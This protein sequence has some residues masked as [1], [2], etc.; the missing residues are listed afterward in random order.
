MSAVA[1]PEVFDR[2]V[3]FAADDRTAETDVVLHGV[4]AEPGI[5]LGQ[6]EL[7]GQVRAE[8][9]ELP[10]LPDVGI[11]ARS[12]V[13]VRGQRR[14]TAGVLEASADVLVGHLLRNR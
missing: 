8:Q 4:A 6:P 11:D 1:L 12:Q 10:A 14:Q 3:D 9:P 2:A 13:V 5:T 7:I